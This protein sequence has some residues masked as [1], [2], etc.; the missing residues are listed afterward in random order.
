MY[1]FTLGKI[2]NHLNSSAYYNRLASRPTLWLSWN[3]NRGGLRC[4]NKI[5]KKVHSHTKVSSQSIIFKV[6][7]GILIS[8]QKKIAKSSVRDNRSNISR[9]S[10]IS[11][12]KWLYSFKSKHFCGLL[13]KCAWL[14]HGQIIRDDS[15]STLVE[16][17]GD[18]YY[19]HTFH[20]E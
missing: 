11:N 3:K 8:G 16:P 5:G 13:A 20:S 17:D 10:L 14:H 2:P 18:G 7:H 19:R 6:Y 9:S 4:A 12:L 15:I 1:S